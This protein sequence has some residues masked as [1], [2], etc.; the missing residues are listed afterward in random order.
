MGINL[1][2]FY[3]HVKAHY[4]PTLLPN[5]LDSISVLYSEYVYKHVRE[6]SCDIS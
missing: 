6:I 2:Y 4:G 3:Y 5:T 1:G